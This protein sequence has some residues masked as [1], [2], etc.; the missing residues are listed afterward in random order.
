M[1]A[2]AKSKFTSIMVRNKQKIM[3]LINKEKHYKIFADI[4]MYI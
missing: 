4:I 3:M 1:P 2:E